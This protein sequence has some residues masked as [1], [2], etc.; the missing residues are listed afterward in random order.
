MSRVFAIASNTFRESIRDKILLSLTVLGFLLIAASKVF[1]PISIGQQA[2][3]IKD[4][5]V[6]LIEIFS[7]LIVVLIGTRILY[8]EIERKTIYSIISKPVTELE[9]VLGK[10]LG[11]YYLIIVI[12]LILFSIFILF[13]KFYLG[14]I[15]WFLLNALYFY[16]FEFLLLDAVAVF[17]SCFTTPITAGILTLL[18]FFVGQLSHYLKDLVVVTGVS[19]LSVLVNFLYFVLPNFSVFNVKANVVYHLPISVNS[20]FLAFSYSILYTLIL[21]IISSLLY[22]LKEYQ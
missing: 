7:L 11:L 17:L 13:M 4:F 1:V 6:G 22:S 8:Q 5:G 16:L 21:L 12:Q 10:F 14:T 19:E 3:I 2:K 15:D 20:Y 9:F 18:V